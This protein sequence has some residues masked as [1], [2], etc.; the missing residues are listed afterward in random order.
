[1]DCNAIIG[2]MKRIASLI[3]VPLAAVLSLHAAEPVVLFEEPFHDHLRDGWTW[4]REEPKAWRIED[5]SLVVDTLPGAMFGKEHSARNVL[6]RP[7]PVSAEQGFIIE[8]QITNDP[9]KTYEHAGIICYFDDDNWAVITKE[10]LP[11]DKTTAVPKV[12]LGSEQ[13]GKPLMPFP[14]K[15][16][17]YDATVWVRV[18]AS[19][20]AFATS[21]YDYG[22]D[23]YVA[24]NNGISPNRQLAITAHGEGDLGYRNF[25]L[26]LFDAITGRKIGPLEEI[27]GTLDTGATAFAARWAKDSSEVQIIYRVDRHVPQKVMAYRLAKGRAIPVTKEP[28]DVKPWDYDAPLVKFWRESKSPNKTFGTPKAHQ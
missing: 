2:V 9:Q 22:A 10:K 12:M 14:D 24:I 23:E 3:I 15:P 8:A 16:G 1:M 27:V 19:T 28:I 6:L 4:L 20:D 21:N 17:Y 7:A 13:D 18:L 11:I 5:N 26:F 25:H